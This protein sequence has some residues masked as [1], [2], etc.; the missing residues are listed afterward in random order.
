MLSRRALCW[1]EICGFEEVFWREAS[2]QC[3]GQ[4]TGQCFS[5]LSVLT[6]QL[7]GSQLG[8]ALLLWPMPLSASHSFV[9][10][11]LLQF[12][13][14][15]PKY[16]VNHMTFSSLY[17]KFM[18]IAKCSSSMQMWSINTLEFSADLSW[19]SSNVGSLYID[20]TCDVTWY[21]DWR[22]ENRLGLKSMRQ[23][24]N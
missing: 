6:R 24:C 8:A 1:Q 23:D 2:E 7:V 16:E 11:W 5:V 20:L 14:T 21:L 22:L 18:G 12:F 3:R 19:A 9:L 15:K 13:M 4:Y 10:L 17:I